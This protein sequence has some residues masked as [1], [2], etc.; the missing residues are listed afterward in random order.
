MTLQ[1]GDI[2]KFNENLKYLREKHKISRKDVASILGITE[3]SYGTYER[4]TRSPDIEKICQLAD[5]FEISIDELVGR[6]KPN[7]SAAKEFWESSNFLLDIHSDEGIVYLLLPA[8][9]RM[10][11]DKN[12]IA[13]FEEGI[14]KSIKFKSEDDFIQFTKMVQNKLETEIQEIKDKLCNEMS[15]DL[16]QQK[17]QQKNSNY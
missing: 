10:I 7:L 9:S 1:G 4:G 2:M 8:E 5:L 15:L 17:Y 3:M 11:T 16:Y 13:R 14:H 6:E 12:G